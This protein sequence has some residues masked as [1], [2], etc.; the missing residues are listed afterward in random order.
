M[1]L[2][3]EVNLSLDEE[4]NLSSEKNIVVGRGGAELVI[5]SGRNKFRPRRYYFFS[6]KSTA[7]KGRSRVAAIG[8]NT[9]GP[10]F[11][12]KHRLVLDLNI[13]L[14]SSE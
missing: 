2:D 14:E 1:S 12:E 11:V 13:K 4:V 3:E 10:E 8:P 6:G 7:R 5:T 9:F